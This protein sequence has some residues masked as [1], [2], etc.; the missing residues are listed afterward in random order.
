VLFAKFH[1]KLFEPGKDGLT[2][3]EICAGMWHYESLLK[4]IELIDLHDNEEMNSHMDQADCGR[5]I[6][7]IDTLRSALNIALDRGKSI[8]NKNVDMLELLLKQI[9]I[10]FTVDSSNF[11]KF[12]L[13]KI[14]FVLL[15]SIWNYN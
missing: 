11:N 13:L 14:Y 4:L 2:P 15:C 5:I 8:N 1:L 6:Y 12:L 10:Q 3:Y 9:R 7:D